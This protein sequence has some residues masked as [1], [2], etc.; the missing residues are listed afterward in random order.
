MNIELQRADKPEITEYPEDELET[1]RR[2]IALEESGIEP[3]LAIE[4]I[5]ITKF[6][7]DYRYEDLTETQRNSVRDTT[8]EAFSR[9]I[10]NPNHAIRD[11]TVRSQV[12]LLWAKLRDQDV[13]ATADMFSIEDDEIDSH[14]LEGLRYICSE[15]PYI[16]DQRFKKIFPILSGIQIQVPEA[17]VV[18]ELEELPEYPEAQPEKSQEPLLDQAKTE[19]VGSIA[20][21]QEVHPVAP[22]KSDTSTPAEDDSATKLDHRNHLTT[23]GMSLDVSIRRLTKDSIEDV[24]PLTPEQLESNDYA[25][26][27][28][29]KIINH[30]VLSREE[31]TELSKDIEVGLMAQHKLEHMPDPDT[32]AEGARLREDLQVL[33]TIGA[34]AKDKLIRHNL[35]LVMRTANDYLQRADYLDFT[36]LFAEGTLG[37]IRGI[38]KYD[39]KKGYTLSTYATWWIKQSIAGAIHRDDRSVYLPKRIHIKWQKI[40]TGTRKYKEEF[41]VE[42]NDTELAAYIDMSLDDVTLVRK[43]ISRTVSLNTPMGEKGDED[44]GDLLSDANEEATASTA[45]ETMLPTAETLSDIIAKHL[46]GTAKKTEA[47]QALFLHCGLPLH[48]DLFDQAFID[49]HNIEPGKAYA[50]ETIG[51]MLNLS[52]NTVQ[53]RITAARDTLSEPHVASLL[54][55]IIAK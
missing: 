5:L 3:K 39:Y 2:E 45:L 22:N 42:A 4:H 13:D 46:S 1:I 51:E 44:L 20:V 24:I 53:S 29:K 14:A 35:R 50:M 9:H 31:V 12:L 49:Q 43:A 33:A 54:R 41:G 37:L 19:Y 52:R 34:E 27:M 18:P 26:I 47:A 40:T 55:D 21:A 16:P 38:E 17:A 8:L 32:D 28:F 7:P 10:E 48:G 25:G 36:D 30:R 11:D 23:P 6:G 15:L